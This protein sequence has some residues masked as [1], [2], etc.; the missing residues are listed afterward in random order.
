MAGGWDLAMLSD[1]ETKI[2]TSA[3]WPSSVLVLAVIFRRPIAGLLPRLR[4]LKVAGVSAELEPE[5]ARA[6]DQAS[7]LASAPALDAGSARGGETAVT[8]PETSSLVQHAAQEPW[9]AARQSWQRIRTAARQASGGT[10]GDGKST[11]S[12]VRALRD[13]G[14]VSDEVYDLTRTMYHLYFTMRK[15]PEQ[16]TPSTASDYADA[17]GKLVRALQETPMQAPVADSGLAEAEADFS[18]R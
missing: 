10:L 8:D 14:R 11:P 12:R 15:A 3:L 7:A 18:S 2:I 5:A 17:A 4:S 6:N 16:V 13:A 1:N 9:W